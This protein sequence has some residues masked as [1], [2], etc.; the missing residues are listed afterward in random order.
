MNDSASITSIQRY[1]RVA[2]VLGLVTIAAGGF[3]EAYVPSVLIVPRDATATARNLI[4][5]ESLFRWGFAAYLVEALCDVALTML[6]YV[7]LRPVH[8]NLALLA[9]FIRV[10]STTGFAMAQ[11]FTFAALSFVRSG[12][13]VAAFTPDQLNALAL[14]SLRVSGYGQAVF[15]MFY[16]TACVILG[17]L[18]YR[19]GYLPKVLGVLIALMGVGFAART[20]LLVVAPRLASPLLLAGAGVAFPALTLWL[21]VKGVDAA[22]WRAKVLAKG[23]EPT[24]QEV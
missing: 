8:R 3:G 1:A 5:S 20:V 14:F 15:T 7:L 19:S 6:F 10:I 9:A 11:V 12:D 24:S 13:H 18:I 16:G 2:G 22:G 17:F 4:A 23:D 21:L